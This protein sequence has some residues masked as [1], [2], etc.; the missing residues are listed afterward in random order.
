MVMG[1]IPGLL[2]LEVRGSGLAVIGSVVAAVMLL[3]DIKDF[4]YGAY[5]LDK[6]KYPCLIP[7]AMWPAFFRN[8]FG[9]TER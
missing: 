4:Q 3:S 1:V 5:N 6:S 8:D 9:W 7:K 2:V